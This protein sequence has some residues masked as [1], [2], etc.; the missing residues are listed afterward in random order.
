MRVLLSILGTLTLLSLVLQAQSS[1]Y[2]QGCPPGNYKCRLQCNPNEYA[3]RY[4]GDWS[5]C[6]KVKRSETMKKNFLELNESF[7]V[8]YSGYLFKCSCDAI[9]KKWK[10]S[11]CPLADEWIKKLWVGGIGVCDQEGG[12]TQNFGGECGI[13]L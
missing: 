11:K 10:P 7:S 8:A 4:C 9:T 3:I 6:C 1:I 13:E 2:T 12:F 5:I